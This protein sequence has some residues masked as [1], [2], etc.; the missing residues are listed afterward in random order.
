MNALG[1]GMLVMAVLLGTVGQ[2]AL[3]SALAPNGPQPLA[4]RPALLLWFVCYTL[5]TVLWIGALRFIPLSQAFPI[6]GLQFALIPLAAARLFKE[7]I[8]VAQFAG[9]A[10]IVLGVA[11]VGQ[12]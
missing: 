4:T 10:L 11:L 7:R 6:L 12:G 5:T 9:I 3:K 2:L 8:S 1:V